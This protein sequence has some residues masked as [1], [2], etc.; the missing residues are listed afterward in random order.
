MYGIVEGKFLFREKVFPLQKDPEWRKFGQIGVILRG[1]RGRCA[2]RGGRKEEH[3]HPVTYTHL[4]PKRT[5]RSRNDH[6]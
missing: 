1:R 4:N 2:A 6:E 3:A 5:A